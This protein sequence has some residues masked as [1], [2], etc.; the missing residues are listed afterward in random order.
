M[1]FFFFFLFLPRGCVRSFFRSRQT[2]VKY[3]IYSTYRFNL[4]FL[5]S[6]LG[7]V[8]L[9]SITHTLSQASRPLQPPRYSTTNK[10]KVH[11]ITAKTLLLYCF[12]STN[13]II[14]AICQKLFTTTLSN[15]TKKKSKVN[16]LLS[17]NS[18]V[19]YCSLRGMVGLT[20]SETT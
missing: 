20:T 5:G 4:S 18:I 19:L 8:E 11:W 2:Q 10:E 17:T 7:D 6:L 3:S 12:F 16:T 1:I 14:R 15:Y 13:D 9:S